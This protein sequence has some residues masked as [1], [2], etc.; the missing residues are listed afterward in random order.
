MERKKNPLGWGK[1]DD[2][3]N[4]EIIS[5][6]MFKVWNKQKDSFRTVYLF[7]LPLFTFHLIAVCF[8]R[9]WRRWSPADQTDH[10]LIMKKLA[11]CFLSFWLPSLIYFPCC[12]RW[13]FTDRNKIMAV[14][15]FI[16]LES[17]SQDIS[18]PPP[19]FLKCRAHTLGQRVKKHKGWKK[20][21]AFGCT[22]YVQRNPCFFCL[23]C[24]LEMTYSHNKNVVFD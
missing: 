8:I 18:N 2:G 12:S 17:I 6:T 20:S 4:G 14:M 19:S 9:K 22:W 1:W 15:R 10:P 11:F 7:I 13:L 5:L 23:Y 24:T 16:T 21:D 3:D